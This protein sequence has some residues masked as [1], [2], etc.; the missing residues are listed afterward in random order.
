MAKTKTQDE[1][2]QE[3]FDKVQT[4]KLAIQKAEKPNW[5]TSCSFGFS[6]NSAHDRT[7]IQ[8]VTDVRKLVEMHAFITER[9][10]RFETSAEELGVSEK[11]SWMGFTADEWKSDMA[12]RVD[13]I[14]LQAKRKELNDLEARLSTLISPE[15]KAKMELAAISNLLAD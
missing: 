7:N 14:Q 12:T 1:L 3:L 10:E 6:P 15:L 13:M 11:F 2:V 9:E 4:K 8:T 5:N